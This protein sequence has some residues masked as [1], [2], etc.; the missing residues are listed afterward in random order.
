M[1]K[2]SSFIYINEHVKKY[3]L[4]IIIEKIA[5]HF[6]WKNV[7]SIIEVYFLKSCIKVVFGNKNNLLFVYIYKSEQ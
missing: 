5:W 7:L 6:I 1:K 3:N 4:K 2:N